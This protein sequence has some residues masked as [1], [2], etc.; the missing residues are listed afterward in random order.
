M[1]HDIIQNL[2]FRIYLLEVDGTTQYW[3]HRFKHDDDFRMDLSTFSA[4]S[5]NSSPD[6]IV[7]GLNAFLESEGYINIA[8]LVSEE[9]KAGVIS[10][11]SRFIERD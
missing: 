7:K 8:E 9:Y 1:K 2:P 11:Q 10:T 6:S 4:I 3:I 5:K